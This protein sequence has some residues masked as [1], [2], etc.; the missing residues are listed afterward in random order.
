VT[1]TDT[2]APAY[3]GLAAHRFLVLRAFVDQGS[4]NVWAYAADI[5]AETKLWSA[6]VDNVLT[7][8]AREGRLTRRQRKGEADSQPRA[9][10][11]VFYMTNAQYE[12]ARS[13]VGRRL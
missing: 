12:Q 13:E 10:W 7:M 2:I 4:A 6:Q 3:Q 11:W 1:S 9:D 5:V 8:L